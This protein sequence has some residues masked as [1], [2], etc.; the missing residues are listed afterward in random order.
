M[1]GMNLTKAKVARR[2]LG[3]ALALFLEDFDPVCVHVLACAGGE[4]AD[5]LALTKGAVPF[6]AHARA[7]VPNLDESR[8]KRVRNQFWNAFKHATTRKG[9]ARD[10]TSLFERFD[11]LQNDHMLF[12]GWYDYAIVAK[13]LPVE[14]QVFQIWYFALYPE[15]LDPKLDRT[16]YKT[17]FPGLKRLSRKR[18]KQALRDIIAQTRKDR[19][20]MHHRLTERTP[21]IAP[22]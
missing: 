4:L 6:S 2:Q 19:A 8:L 17:N 3:T 16:P 1:R 22:R 7:V 5:N 20:I 12:I 21:L 18:Q 14:A 13:A 10:D 9:I 11:D 15:K